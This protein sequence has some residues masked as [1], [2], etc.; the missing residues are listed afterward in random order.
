MKNNYTF[1]AIFDYND[2]D[3]ILISF[4]DFENSITSADRDDE[5]IEMAQDYLTLLITDYEMEKKTLPIPSINIKKLS[6]NQKLVYVN[7]WMP[8]HRSK[9]KETYVKKTLTIPAWLDILA[10]RNN[11]NFSSIL[12]K[13]LKSELALDVNNISKTQK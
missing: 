4:P 6:N 1:P 3:Y 8:Y 7:I 2:P 13:G 9:I 11:V 12:V 10:K 5:C